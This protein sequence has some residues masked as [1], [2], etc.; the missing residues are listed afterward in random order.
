MHGLVLQGRR[1][2]LHPANEFIP[3]RHVTGNPAWILTKAA[4]DYE[5]SLVHQNYSLFLI[6]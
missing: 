6:Y 4:A 1:Q 3:R 5:T 2:H